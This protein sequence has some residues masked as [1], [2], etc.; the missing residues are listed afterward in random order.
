MDR[1]RFLKT[2]ANLGAL[3]LVSPL[4]PSALPAGGAGKTAPVVFLKT[5]DRAS[6]V[7][8]AIDLLELGGAF[9]GKDLLVKP[10]FNSSDPPPGSTHMETL[11]A[12][13]KKL[14]AMGAGP[15]TVGDRSGMGDTRT[16]FQK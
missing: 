7:S 14:K 10:N 4:I 5:G 3:A 6:G 13:L 8:R 1:R 12:L 11:G 9:E 16:V 15:I 2:A